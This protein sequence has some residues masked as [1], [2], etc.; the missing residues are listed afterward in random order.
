LV[1]QTLKIRLIGRSENAVRIQVAVALFAFL[2]LRLAHTA[3]QAVT[4]CSPSPVW[5]AQTLCTDDRSTGCSFRR[6]RSSRSATVETLAYAKL[7][8]TP[9][10]R[11][12]HPSSSK[13]GLAKI[14]GCPD[15]P[16]A[17]RFKLVT[18]CMALILLCSKRLATFLGHGR[19]IKPSSTYNSVSQRIEA[20][21]M[22]SLRSACAEHGATSMFA[23]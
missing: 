5:C 11:P 22:A 16:T 3:Q 13:N 23:P 15:K 10:A 14:D 17:V 4:A 7:N 8:R 12:R 1:K 20:S 9:W 18:R 2:L 19:R 6:L 21:S